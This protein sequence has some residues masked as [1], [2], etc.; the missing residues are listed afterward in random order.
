MWKNATRNPLKLQELIEQE[1]RA[2]GERAREAGRKIGG[3]REGGDGRRQFEQLDEFLVSICSILS[4]SPT[5]GRAVHG[6]GADLGR[7][8]TV[9]VGR[10]EAVAPKG[11][12]RGGKR[13][14]WNWKSERGLHLWNSGDFIQW[15]GAQNQSVGSEARE[16]M[17]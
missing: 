10:S 14:A 13:P 4:S 7:H 1:Q 3:R 6:S 12:L 5:L 2:P 16:V 11:G 17:R 8:V 9:A 15:V